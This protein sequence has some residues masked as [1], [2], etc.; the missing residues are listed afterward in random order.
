MIDFH[1]EPIQAKEEKIK[2][3][4]SLLKSLKPVLQFVSYY[5]ILPTL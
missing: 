3:V 2:N 1:K 4:E 5:P